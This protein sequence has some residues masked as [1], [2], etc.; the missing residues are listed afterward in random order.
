MDINSDSARGIDSPGEV[1]VAS[2][3]IKKCAVWINPL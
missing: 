2:S 1:A 3:K